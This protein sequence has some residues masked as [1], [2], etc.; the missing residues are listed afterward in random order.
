M[1]RSSGIR[2]K[3]A[4][5]V[6]MPLVCAVPGLCLFALSRL[7]AGEPASET[8][9]KSRQKAAAAIL[10]Q[11]CVECHGGR[12]TRSGL[13]LA[14][15]EGLLKG[16]VGGPAFIA[17]ETARSPLFE[18]ITH[19]VEPG[20]PFKRKKLADGEIALLRSWLD[21]GAGYSGPLRKLETEDEWWSLRPLLKPAVS[22]S[23]SAADAAWVRTPVDPFI[24]AKLKEKG[25]APSPPADKRTLLRRVMFDLTG[26]PPTPAETAVFL[27]DEAPDAYE[28]LVDRLLASSAYGERWA[29]HWMDMVHYAETHGND[30]DRPRPNAWPYRDYLIRSLNDDK[31]YARF[32][33]E[34]LAGDVLYPDDANA[35]VAMGFLA[36]GP[37][38]ESSLRDIREDTIDREIARYLDRDDIVTT[39]MSTLLSTTVHCA[40]CHEHKFDPITQEEYYKLQAVFAGV[41]KAE[42]AFDADPNFARRRRDLAARKSDLP[43]LAAKAD[44]SLLAEGVQA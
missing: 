4:V 25:L 21:D 13:D 43:A 1:R 10:E 29:R 18:R 5:A 8:D 39:A 33:E 32:I 30:Q 16:G 31:P 2:S 3:F 11:H 27:A 41:D 38:D 12:L 7:V 24:L 28:Q 9:V 40:R 35:I 17:G 19:A 37:W 14:T 36:T 34:Q 26:L 22:K 44:L 42:R 15:R 20:M 6:R 23:L